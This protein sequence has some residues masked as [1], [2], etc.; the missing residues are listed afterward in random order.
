MGKTTSQTSNHS[1]K[2]AFVKNTSWLLIAEVVAKFSRIATVV[3]MATYLAPEQYGLA[4]LAVGC[5]EILRLVMR[6]G[7][8]AQIVQ[9][10]DAQLPAYAA[11]GQALQWMLC[12]VLALFQYL[13]AFPIAEF[14][15]AEQ[16][17]YLI[18]S[19][20]LVYLIFPLVT[21][22]VAL[23]QRQHKLRYLSLCNCL[24]LVAENLGIALLLL[25]GFGLD[26]III[27]KFIFAGVWVA[28]FWRAPV[29]QFGTA[30][31]PGIIKHLLSVSYKL[32]GA[33]LCKA[34]RLHADL[35]IA[36]KLLSPVWFGIYTF[37]R[38]MGVGLSQSL[39]NAYN[40]A[41]YPMLCSI[42]RQQAV[43]D[44]R[45]Y[46]VAGIAV[47]SCVFLLQAILAPFYIPLLF[48]NQWQAAIPVVSI[49][50][51]AAIP[52]LLLDTYCT[53]QRASGQYQTEFR[54]RLSFSLLSIVILLVATPQTPTSFALT[55]LAGC[56]LW[57]LYYVSKYLVTTSKKRKFAFYSV[58]EKL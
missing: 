4:M 47:L 46:L 28:A 26:A 19:M 40:S 48:D 15:Q 58:E 2:K 21:V 57:P 35:F 6:C 12:V 5:H 29:P 34:L 44:K 54:T 53:S 7:A 14:Y 37:A 9:C 23:L 56:S 30:F 10:S 1:E 16:I 17:G 49:L 39:S 13:L 36:G 22:K 51:C 32:L 11:N 20:A 31:N 43:T 24:C 52:M 38:N 25:L 18:Q 42:H 45:W 50:C 55:V 41:L 3:V 33:E 8:S 27:G